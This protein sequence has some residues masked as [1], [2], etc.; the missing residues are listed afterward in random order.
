MTI[1][2]MGYPHVHSSSGMF[3]KFIP[4]TPA[5]NVIGMKIVA[6]MVRNFITSFS[7]WL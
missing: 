5:M 1:R 3:L 4:Y 7:L 6:T 2:A